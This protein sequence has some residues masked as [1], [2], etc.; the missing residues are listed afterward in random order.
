M[1]SQ[2]ERSQKD[3]KDNPFQVESDERYA[4]LFDEGEDMTLCIAA[5]CWIDDK[6]CLAYCCDTRAER[7]G[8]FHELAGSE[9]AWKIR[10]IGKN[11]GLVAGSET[12]ADR[13]LALCDSTIRN[14][15]KTQAGDNSELLIDAL[16]RD[17]E[18]HAET[19]KKQI[20]NHWL[21]FEFGMS[22]TKFLSDHKQQ[23][24]PEQ[25]REIWRTIRDKDLETDLLICGYQ[26]DDPVIVRLDRFGKAHWETNYSVIGAGSDIA[27][28]FL[29]QHDWDDTPSLI[30]CAYSLIEAKTA[31]ERNRHVG[32][33][34]YLQFLLPDGKRYD[35]QEKVF[36]RLDSTVDRR[37]NYKAPAFSM[38]MLEEIKDD[39]KPS[40]T[41][42]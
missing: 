15:G 30:Q 36:D 20:I 22:Y 3:N 12:P 40:N 16:L 31:A 33:F 24:D 29:S 27:I 26:D 21:E 9:D 25:A 18:G 1:T 38:D 8:V 6:P 7:G 41:T 4:S 34:T 17:L 35:L 42:E 19:R 10:V 14:F 11:V 32:E 28:S 37:R 23:L 5:D 39:E 2:D 13:L